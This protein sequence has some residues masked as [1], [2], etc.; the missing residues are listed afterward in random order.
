LATVTI[1]VRP[2][3]GAATLGHLV[4][5]HA[6]L[7]PAHGQQVVKRGEQPVPHAVIALAGEARIVAHLDFRD[8]VALDL[9]QRRQ[10]TV[11]AL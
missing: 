11:H 6:L 7:H 8:R 1:G 4:F 5:E 9:E 10:E 2:S 3:P